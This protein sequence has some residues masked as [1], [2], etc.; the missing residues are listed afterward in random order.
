MN[1]T[2]KILYVDD[3]FLNFMLFEVLFKD[4]FVVFIAPNVKKGLDIFNKNDISVVITDQKMPEMSGVKFLK[5]VIKKN[6]NTLR[7]IHSGYLH[8]EEVE[9]GIKEG[10]VNYFLDKPLNENLLLDIIEKYIK[11][12]M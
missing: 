2:I 9:E 11:N 7:I 3:D 5:E 4:K 12:T 8:N 10:V 6:S 1:K